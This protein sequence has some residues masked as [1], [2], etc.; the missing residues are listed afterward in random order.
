MHITKPHSM[1]LHHFQFILDYI[2]RGRF[3]MIASNQPLY[4]NQILHKPF[5]KRSKNVLSYWYYITLIKHQECTE[6]L[7]Q[8]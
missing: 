6:S 5:E 8:T 2:W 1:L 3:Y 7:E 4:V